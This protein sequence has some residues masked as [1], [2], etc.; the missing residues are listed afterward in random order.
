VRPI[1]LK[2]SIEVIHTY[3]IHTIVWITSHIQLNG[4]MKYN[5]KFNCMNLSL[6]SHTIEWI[7]SIELGFILLK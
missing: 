4:G 3:I 1:Q 6:Y 7:T 5:E 2:L